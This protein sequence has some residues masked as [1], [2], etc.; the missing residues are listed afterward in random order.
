MAAQVVLAKKDVS[1]GVSLMF[2]AQNLGS[3]IFVSVAQNVLADK[4]IKNLS[5]IAGLNSRVVGKS[6]ATGLRNAVK[7]GLLGPVQVAYNAAIRNAYY[8]GLAMACATVIG[9]AGME[10]KNLKD[11]EKGGPPS[12]KEKKIEQEG[13]G[14]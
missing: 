2:F 10:W 9:A 13:E 8:V 5:Q 1:I 6:G 3:T 7:P 4:L 14:V 11:G 12:S